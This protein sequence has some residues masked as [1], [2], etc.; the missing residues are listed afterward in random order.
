MPADVDPRLESLLA[1]ADRTAPVK[2]VLALSQGHDAHQ[3][4]SLLDG[5]RQATGKDVTGY[6]YLDRLNVLTVTAEPAVIRALID[7]PG[8]VRV[9]TGDAEITQ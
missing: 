3:V 9:T 7:A 5:V 6:N 1:R 8:V 4:S 2:A